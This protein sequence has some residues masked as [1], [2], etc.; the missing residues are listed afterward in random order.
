MNDSPEGRG[1][2]DLHREQEPVLPKGDI[3]MLRPTARAAF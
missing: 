1:Q 2:V 3:W